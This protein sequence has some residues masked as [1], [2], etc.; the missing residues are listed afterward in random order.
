MPEYSDYREHTEATYCWVSDGSIRLLGYI[1]VYADE[2]ALALEIEVG[3]GKLV[4]E[5]H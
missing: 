1:E 5:R 4:G 2:D 3:D